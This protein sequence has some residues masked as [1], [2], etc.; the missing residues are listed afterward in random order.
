MALGFDRRAGDRG[1]AACNPP[2]TLT[3][4]E[5]HVDVLRY[6]VPFVE[7]YLGEQASVAPLLGPPTGPGFSYQASL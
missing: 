5:A 4:D 1:S 3:Q 2:T 7:R 6:V